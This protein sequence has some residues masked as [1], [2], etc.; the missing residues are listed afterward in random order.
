MDGALSSSCRPIVGA[1]STDE[2]APVGKAPSQVPMKKQAVKRHHHKHNLKHRYEFLETLGKGTYGK[3][4]KAKERSGRLVAVKSIRKEKIKDEQDLVH[5]RRE[6]EIMSSLCHP[7]IITIYE[8]FENKD[9][10]V[11]VMEYASRGD[12]YD[13]ICDKRNISER[14]ARHFFRQIVSAVHYCHQNGI[15][16]RD[17]KLENILLDGNGNVKIADFGLSNLYQNDEYLQT[18]CGSPLYASPEI[19]NGRP[20]RGPE[21]DTWSLGVLLYTLVH[22]TMPFDGNSHK[23]LVQQISTG[24]YRKPNNPSDACGLIRWMLMVNPERR[25]TIEEIAGHWWLNWGYQHPILSERKSS[26]AEQTPSPVS[27]ST[28][29]P[30]G[31][32]SVASWLRRTSRPL[33]ENGSKMRC[34]LRSQGG[35]G[36]VVRQRSLRRSRKENNV[37]QTVHEGSTDT[38]PSKGILKRRN[39]VKQKAMTETPAAGSVDPQN[40]LGLSA[41][42]DAPSDALLPR[43][44]ILKK[45]AEHESG[46]YSSSPENSDSGWVPPTKECPSAPT[47]RKGI[48]KRNGKFSSGGLQ[49]FGSLDQ[50]AASLPR[51][52]TR[53]RPSGAISKDSIL[54]SESFDQLDLPDHVRP[55]TEV[56]KPAKASMRGCVSAD[57]LLDIQEDRIL[58]DGLLKS[59]NCYESGVADSAFSITDCDNVTEAYKQAMVIRGSAAS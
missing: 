21:V 25:A 31:L 34:L 51:S 54:S 28:S 36:D 33:L 59:W 46:Y 4:K 30:A 29:H 5:I 13:Y 56:D 23:I 52:S 12:L 20:Y 24:N 57:N 42:A 55:P 58:A 37:S 26:T 3:V 14:E 47:Y 17:L 49:E 43:K 53:S 1:A 39:S 16:H 15:V 7:H 8:V 9:K 10:I 32:A 44:G 11:I 22:G 40:I 50:L 6:I 41:P 35:G 18:F 38:R 27:P 48:L 45:P 19:V 2:R